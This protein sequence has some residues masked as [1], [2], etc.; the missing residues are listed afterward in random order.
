VC[1]L[2]DYSTPDVPIAALP[3]SKNDLVAS[4][5][6]YTPAQNPFGLT[7]TGPALEGAIAYARA[8]AEEHPTRRSIVLL[9]TD[10]APTGGC[11]PSRRS[12]IAALASVGAGA[13][14]PVRTYTI[15]VFAPEDP[16][17]PSTDASEGPDT[18]RAI[19]EAGT[20]EAFVIS[21]QQDVAAEFVDA[22]NAVRGHGLSCDFQIPS[23]AAGKTLDYGKVNVEFTPKAGEDSEVIP[24]VDDGAECGSEGGWYY[25]RDTP[26]STPKS[27]RTCNSTCIKLQGSVTGNI[28]I[29]VG[30]ETVRR[31]PI[32]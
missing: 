26:K 16:N 4:L 8:W 13:T 30:C 12:E 2:E 29:Q 6:A 14:V 28:E 9:A 7:P 21:D 17:N 10:G 3:A 27:I 5:E 19:A 31:E 18:I 20:G 23:P 32:K 25:E 11:T 1:T 24:Y 22:L 15:G